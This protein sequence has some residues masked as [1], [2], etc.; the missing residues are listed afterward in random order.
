MP[1]KKPSSDPDVIQDAYE[2]ALG[3][4]FKAYFDNAVIEAAGVTIPDN[5]NAAERFAVGVAILKACR[6]K[7]IEL[8][9]KGNP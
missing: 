6:D 1:A 8:L 7:A 4:H 2:D 9:A 3:C 5:K